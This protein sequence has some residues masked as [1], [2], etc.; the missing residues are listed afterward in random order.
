MVNE[1]IQRRYIIKKT[2]AE[3]R[4]YDEVLNTTARVHS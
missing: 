3:F 2:S 1:G 4:Q